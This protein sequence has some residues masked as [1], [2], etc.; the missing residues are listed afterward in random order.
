MRGSAGVFVDRDGTLIRDVGYLNRLEQIEVL[1]RV[2]EAICLLRQHGLR[3]ALVTNQSAVAR[4]LLSEEDLAAIH[5]ELKS[6]LGECGAS[7]DRIYFCPHHPT[8]GIGRY[9]IT[10]DCRKPNIA[11]AKRAAAELNLDL[12]RC[13]VVGDQGTDMEFAA[14]IGARGIHIQGGIADEAG[15]N[16]KGGCLVVKDLWE[17]ASWIVRNLQGLG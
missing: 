8:E 12:S 7:L 17:A 5:R 9:R 4:G 13:Y 6:R 11:L 15:Q 10:C 3:V 2:A 14:R 1:P 16:V